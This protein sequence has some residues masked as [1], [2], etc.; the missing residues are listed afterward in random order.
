MNTLEEYLSA[1]NDLVPGTHPRGEPE[2]LKAINKALALHSKYRPRRIVEDMA[3]TGSFDYAL[4]GLAAWSEGFSVVLQVEYPVD[5]ECEEPNVL[6]E[7]D[8]TI[9]EKPA[10][11][12][13]R[14]P[15]EKP[16]AGESIRVTYTAPHLF[17]VD[18][19]ASVASTDIEA[20]ETLAAAF[21]C[22]QLAAAYAQDQDSTIRADSVDHS[23]KRREYEAQA[24]KY[25][26]EYN[27][28]LGI[29]EGKPKPASAVQD[30][31][32]GYPFGWDYLTHPRRWR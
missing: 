8:W 25:R 6:E 14:F 7:D 18:D 10:G 28:A 12:C 17:N 23:S 21:F 20:V 5:D 26:R 15:G 30:L 22:R 24:Q 31:D 32:S 29:E 4:G 13:L 19:A 16:K 2:K 1:I 9:Y 11:K 3:G 27:E